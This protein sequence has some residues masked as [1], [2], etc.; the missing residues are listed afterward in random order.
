MDR[1]VTRLC[2]PRLLRRSY[3]THS[4]WI[5]A[6]VNAPST[7]ALGRAVR[8]LRV[9]RG[10]SQDALAQA[11]ELHPTYLSGI[12]RG[13]RNPTWRTLARLCA[14]LQVDMSELA[15]L[16]EGQDE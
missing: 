11:S 6:A 7:A 8:E 15:R 3:F 16:A 12:E 14:A 9:D 4:L 2:V 1:V 10:L 5:G 13:A